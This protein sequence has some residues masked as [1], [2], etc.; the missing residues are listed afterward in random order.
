MSARTIAGGLTDKD[1]GSYTWNPASP[2][3]AP[4]GTAFTVFLAGLNG[5]DDGTCFAD[6]CDWRIPTSEELQTILLEPAP[7]GAAPCID[8]TV[9]GPQN[10]TAKYWSSTT[11]AALVGDAWLVF[12]ETGGGVTSF[13]KYFPLSV[14]AVRGGA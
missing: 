5:A 6:H 7:C 12:F 8:Q 2:G 11:N 9:F 14:R 1:N 10:T 3:T 13:P 4:T